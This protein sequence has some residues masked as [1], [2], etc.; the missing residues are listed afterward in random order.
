[1]LPAVKE[2]LLKTA[3]KPTSSAIRRCAVTLAGIGLAL[4]LPAAAQAS[5]VRLVID[6]GHG[7]KDPGAMSG[8][9]KEKDTNLQISRAVAK[10]ARRQGWEVEMT[11]KTDKFVPLEKRPQSANRKR[12]DVFVS[13]HSNSMGKAA[14]GNMTI[15]RSKQG[16][17]LGRAI[18][19][20]MDRMT[21]YKD[22]GNRRDTRGLAV[23]RASKRPAVI[24]EV[25]SV[26]APKER[27][28][29]KDPKAQKKYA[30]AIVRGVATYEG[31]K[32]KEPVKPKKKVAQEKEFT[33]LSAGVS[34]EPVN[35]ARGSKE[36]R[37]LEPS[38]RPARTLLPGLIGLLR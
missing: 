32:Y 34:A 12:A 1:M 3:A 13:I 2:R 36:F 35:S 8:G 16:K 30:E 37:V 27:K 18:M 19:R 11:R 9:V 21:E 5:S 4:A 7:G 31:V 33:P 22:I 20:E 14:K 38:L 24:V 29:I 6:P 17:R 25:L 15:Y 26:A 10:A 28:Q 23:L